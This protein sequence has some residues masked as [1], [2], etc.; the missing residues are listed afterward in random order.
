MRRTDTTGRPFPWLDAPHRRRSLAARHARRA[1][2]GSALLL[3]SVAAAWWAGGELDAAREAT[4]AF[5]PLR[6]VAVA[7]G[8]LT[9]GQVVGPDDVTRRDLPAALVP[10]S[11]VDDPVGRTVTAAVLTGE[12]FVET[13][14]APPGSTGSAAALRA[15]ERAV[16]VPVDVLAP[17]LTPGDVIEVVLAAAPDGWG[18]PPSAE[19]ARRVAG[20]VLAT[21]DDHLSV[22]V[23]ADDAA[24]VAMAALDGRVS[25]L[26][27]GAE[28]E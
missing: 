24:S 16:A 19:G 9:F 3:T 6:Q 2:V 26:A 4:E 22:A 7:A 27:V 15:G 28:P 10:A 11:P 1:V 12:P 8:S 25:L 20:R 5:G 23:D 18:A 21:G 17:E 13:R 14:L